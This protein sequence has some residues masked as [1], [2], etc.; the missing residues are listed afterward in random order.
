MVTSDESLVG[1]ALAGDLPAF[2]VL[3]ERYT[4]LVHAVVLSRAR[5]CDEV[6]DL[7]QESFITAY[8]S[9]AALRD[10]R[11]FGPWLGQVARTTVLHW[12]RHRNARAR[13]EAQSD[14]WL[15]TNVAPADERLERREQTEALSAALDQ[16]SPDQRQI[17]LLYHTEDCS[18][19]EL[20]RMLGVSVAT[21]HWRLRRAERQLSR[22][23]VQRLGQTARAQRLDGQVTARRVLAAVSGAGLCVRS[24]EALTAPWWAGWA[25]LTSA[26]VW[27]PMAGAAVFLAAAVGHPNWPWAAAGGPGAGSA[28]AA[29][30]QTGRSIRLLLDR[31]SLGRPAP[32]DDWSWP[33]RPPGAGPLLPLTGPDSWSTAGPAPDWLRLP[34]ETLATACPRAD[35][36]P[37]EPTARTSALVVSVIEYR[38]GNPRRDWFTD[39]MPRLAAYLRHSPDFSGRLHWRTLSLDDPAVAASGLLYLTGNDGGL[40]LGDREK[41]SLGAYLRR[42]GLLFAE[43]IRQSDGARGLI[44]QGA[45]VR[46]TP[47]DRQFKALMADPLVLGWAGRAWERVPMDHP[48]YTTPNRFVSGLPRGA[49]PGGQAVFLEM[50]RVD[51][52]AAV[53]FSDLNVSWYWANPRTDEAEDGLRFGANLVAYALRRQ[54]GADGIAARMPVVATAS[55]PQR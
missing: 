25:W 8:Q 2:G 20:A 11:R 40:L 54:M 26:K 29:V 5:C 49:S 1:R 52:R 44:G 55:A 30:D 41:A 27:W 18:H 31:G 14:G 47:F 45:G 43:D 33:P 21:A 36:R 12:A 50:L 4:G 10:P 22:S 34:M 19:R 7:V 3:V 37:P 17:V 53:V 39:A 6:D 9:L 24:A 28:R 23:L 51:D 13:A 48:L 42:G 15:S 16:L 46:G 38:G 35:R 32:G